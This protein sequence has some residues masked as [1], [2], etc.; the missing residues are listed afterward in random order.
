MLIYPICI[1]F[2]S[3]GEMI[4]VGVSWYF[5]GI[6][7]SNGTVYEPETADHKSTYASVSL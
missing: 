6:I 7:I 1:A 5:K 2:D 4:V 3:N